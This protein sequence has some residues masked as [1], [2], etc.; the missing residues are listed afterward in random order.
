MR[1]LS[2]IP[3]VNDGADDANERTIVDFRP[4]GGR[5]RSEKVSTRFARGQL[6]D[7][8]RTRVCTH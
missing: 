7:E 1:H 2:I 6:F 3:T 8:Q 5:G 4:R